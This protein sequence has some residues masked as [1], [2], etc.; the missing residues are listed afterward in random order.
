MM[1]TNPA[2]TLGD[3]AMTQVS[4]ASRANQEEAFRVLAAL[5]KWL[6]PPVA[7]FLNKQTRKLAA[8]SVWFQGALARLDSDPSIREVF[9]NPE[10]E[11]LLL[12]KMEEAEQS[13]MSVRAISLKAARDLEE[14]DG[15]R[16]GAVRVAFRNAAAAAADAIDAMQAFKWA[17]M[18]RSADTDIE[19]GRVQTFSNADDL[20]NELGR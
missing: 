9:G 19:A 2:F 12:K 5:G 1:G 3:L 14:M 17:V 13:L 10:A 16:D 4:A 20:L 8:G 18:E 15:R 11:D 6:G 7:Y